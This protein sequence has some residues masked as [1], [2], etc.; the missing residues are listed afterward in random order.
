[1]QTR[2]SPS[3]Q[4]ANLPSR[5]DPKAKPAVFPF[6]ILENLDQ[7]IAVIAQRQN[8][9]VPV[10]QRDLD[11]FAAGAEQ[12]PEGVQVGPVA[13]R[14]PELLLQVAVGVFRVSIFLRK[15]YLAHRFS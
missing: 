12:V 11:G 4:S 6:R 9:V 5:H 1:M 3:L 2:F 15:L 13:G 8:Q 10:D 14:Q 7:F